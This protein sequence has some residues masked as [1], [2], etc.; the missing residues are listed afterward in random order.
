M[1]V[2]YRQACSDAA[3]YEM[4]NPNAGVII[5]VTGSFQ[6]VAAVRELSIKR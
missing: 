1:I 5:L 6:T 2:S 4:A 3:A